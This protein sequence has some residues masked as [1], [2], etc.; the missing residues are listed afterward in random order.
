[1]T[2]LTGTLAEIRDDFQ[3]LEQNDRLQLLLEFS[4][5]LPELPERYR[6]HPDLLERVE[7]CQA[8]VY[9]FVE[10]DGDGIVHLYA[11]APAE[12]PTTRGFASILV[13]GLAGLTADEVLAV[14]DDFPQTL[15]LA[16]AVSPLRL[17]GMSALLGR[18]KRQVRAKLAA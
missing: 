16:Q 10:V 12:A 1:M 2:E 11:T 13:Q 18:A 5:E 9:I 4:D 15:G 7:E 14:P 17:R 3:A 6:D 8:P